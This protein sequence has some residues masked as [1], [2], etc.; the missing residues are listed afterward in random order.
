MPATHPVVEVR[1]STRRRKTAAATWQGQKIVVTLPARL[2]SAAS[3]EMV[4]QLVRRLMARQPKFR[5]SDADLAQRASELADKYL[6]GLRPGSIRWVNNQNKRWG[7]CSIA[8]GDI[9]I[10]D[11]LRPVPGWVL[12]AVLVHEMAHI[13]E[14]NHSAHFR[15]IV[16]R[17]P[18]TADA[19]AFLAGYTL[20]LG[21]PHELDMNT[22]QE[23]STPRCLTSPRAIDSSSESCLGLS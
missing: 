19:D 5:S 22:P 18:K 21:A 15:S 16:A 20:G 6:E 3:T 13:L 23:D 9:R 17:Y 10:S 14:P 12:D 7:S 4:E 1:V 8:S 2:G 11:R